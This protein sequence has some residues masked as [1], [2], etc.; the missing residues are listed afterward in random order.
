MLSEDSMTNTTL[1]INA[2][3]TTKP[4]STHC[5]VFPDMSTQRF[6]T[7]PSKYS[8]VSNIGSVWNKRDGKTFSKKLI[9]VS[10]GINVTDG[11]FKIKN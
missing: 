5:I 6:G 7:K 2:M 9:N 11:I 4:S 1:L 8:E 10:Y 3:H